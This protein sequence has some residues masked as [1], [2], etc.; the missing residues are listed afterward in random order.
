MDLLVIVLLAG[1]KHA[2]NCDYDRL[3][4]WANE[5]R[6]LR[7]IMG[8]GADDFKRY[9][10][11]CI[12]DN[13]SKCSIQLLEE[14]NVLIVKLGHKVV[15]QTG[16]TLKC[17]SDSKV[18]KTNVHYPTDLSLLWDA[19]R[20]L[21]VLSLKW[22]RFFG[23]TGWRQNKNLLRKIYNAF[24]SARKGRKHAYR[25]GYVQAYLDR[26]DKIR[27]K[28]VR[29]LDLIEAK[30]LEIVARQTSGQCLKKEVELLEDL[31]TAKH[32]ISFDYLIMFSDQITRRIL[33]G[34]TI[35][36]AEKVFSIFKPFTRWIVKGKVGIELGVPVAVVE[37][38]HQFILGHGVLW[39]GTDKDIA[40]ELIREV[41]EQF[42]EFNLTCSFDRS[43]Y[44]PMVRQELD[45]MLEVTAMPSK[46]N[47]TK[48]EQER[49]STPDYK[50]ARKG[51]SAVESCMNNLNHRRMD[52]V[53]E[54]KPEAFARAVAL[55]VLSANI[56]RL[57]TIILEQA[58][59]QRQRYRRA[60]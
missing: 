11:Q 56:H 37:D 8:H 55:S 28:A 39:N 40:V 43:F 38:E 22:S 13:V 35:E 7:Q 18:V 41:Q 25:K 14:I 15:G 46:G 21:I 6:V 5:L 58:R 45:T 47:P 53:R 20:C 12:H 36:H 17:R 49:Q 59:K 29:L 54:V 48:A 2:T 27:L 32:E 52:V 57:G 30:R 1:L 33:R 9:S 24:Q 10:R 31:K 44:S 34:E 50:E 16:G 3:T 26:C 60:A 51:H 4:V 19:T 42:P 23:F